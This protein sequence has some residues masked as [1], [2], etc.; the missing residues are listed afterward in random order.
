MVVDRR[1]R[2][3]AV[4]QKMHGGTSVLRGPGEPGI[5]YSWSV[6]PSQGPCP[7][8][9]TSDGQ[10][11]Q[12]GPSQAVS[13]RLSV[14]AQSAMPIPPLVQSPGHATRP[15][16]GQGV[17]QPDRSYL[18][19][20]GA[21][22]GEEFTWSI[23]PTTAGSVVDGQGTEQVEI[24][25]N[26]HTGNA[27]VTVVSSL[28]NQQETATF[29]VIVSPQ[30]NPVISQTG[31]LCP[32][33]FNPAELTTS[34]PGLDHAWTDPNGLQGFNHE[35]IVQNAGEHEVTVTDGQGCY[36]GYFTVAAPVPVA[37]ITSPPRRHLHSTFIAMV[38]YRRPHRDGPTVEHGPTASS[39]SHMIQ[40]LFGSTTIR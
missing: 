21:T 31:D 24:Q 25:W 8:T 39:Q 20:S 6:S 16:P 3:S 33:A 19:T 36:G 17:R 9:G 34:S 2:S 28:C 30:P 37:D 38:M 15:R 23:S 22:N 12:H 1:A 7:T 27:M 5:N 4:R 13:E 11:E 29:T 10:L 14:P 35:F 18:G 26:D 32:G 40:N